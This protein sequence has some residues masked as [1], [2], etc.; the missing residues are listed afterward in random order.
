MTYVTVGDFDGVHQGHRTLLRRMVTAAAERNARTLAITFD[1]NAKAFLGGT[2]SLC[3]SSPEEKR[4]L[5][6]AEGVDEVVSLPFDKAFSQISANKFLALLRTKFDC[7]DLFGGEDFR[8]GRNGVGRLTDGMVSEGILQHVVDFKTDF[9]KISSSS[10]RSAL[11]DGLVDRAN[12][13][14]GYAYSISGVV[15]EGKHLGRTI[16]FP[17]INITPPAEKVL[18]CNG[19][20]ITETLSD[21]T[22]YRSVTNVGVRPTVESNGERNVETHLLYADGDFYGKAVTVRFLAHLRDEIHFPDVSVMMQ[23][24]RAD[25][26]AA[27]AWHENGMFPN[28]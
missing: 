14:L 16:G 4:A 22:V 5:I 25:R 9:V 27:F 18:P 21:G 1:R 7:T 17:T 12:L 6:L 28:Q 26:D 2:P 15:T 20:Y 8:F 13:W 19:V 3:L 23:Q 10:I 24:L 11:H